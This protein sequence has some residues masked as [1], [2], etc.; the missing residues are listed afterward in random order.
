MP[1]AELP[2]A[3]LHWRNTDENDSGNT[4]SFP[5]HRDDNHGLREKKLRK[6]RTSPKDE[7]AHQPTDTV[8]LT[9][10]SLKLIDWIPSSSGMA[11]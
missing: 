5:C 3:P 6:P 2:G 4:L 7:A 11:K 1:L 8:H 10:E 9:D